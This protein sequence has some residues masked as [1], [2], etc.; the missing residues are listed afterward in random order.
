ML[1][2]IKITFYITLLLIT[3]LAL[4]YVVTVTAVE[5][6]QDICT[7]LLKYR[8]QKGWDKDTKY[9]STDNVKANCLKGEV[10]RLQEELDEAND[11]LNAGH[12]D[13]WVLDIGLKF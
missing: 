3:L 13:S 11:T 2:K 9:G 4:P 6:G 5:A 1:Q 12:R 7:K 8:E 10:N